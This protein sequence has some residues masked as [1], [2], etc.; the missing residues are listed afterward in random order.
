[1]VIDK[2]FVSRSFLISLLYSLSF[3]VCPAFFVL[4]CSV[5]SIWTY[6]HVTVMGTAVT[7]HNISLFSSGV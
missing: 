6:Y 2:C 5:F 1:M 3:S 7:F 4:N